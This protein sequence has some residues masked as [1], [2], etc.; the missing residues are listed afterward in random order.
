MQ[1]NSHRD[2]RIAELERCAYILCRCALHVH[3][4]TVY[5]ELDRPCGDPLRRRHAAPAIDARNGSPLL[6]LS[7][8]DHVKSPLHRALELIEIEARRYG[9]AVGATALLSRVPLS[10]LLETLAGRIALD[11][12]PSQVIE[13]NLA[14]PAR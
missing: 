2:E 14:K 6:V 7:C 10:A 5:P 8:S 4:E 12:K 13:T 9:G 1:C 11:A 3:R